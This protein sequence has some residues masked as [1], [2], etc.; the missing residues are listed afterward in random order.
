MRNLYVN[1]GRWSSHR[2][3][4][5]TNK[6]EKKDEQM[7]AEEWHAPGL[8]GHSD[9][10]FWRAAA[11]RTTNGSRRAYCTAVADMLREWKQ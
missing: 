6:H 1:G 7:P 2:I 9:E 11:E 3:N 4:P 10:A 8:P 5:E